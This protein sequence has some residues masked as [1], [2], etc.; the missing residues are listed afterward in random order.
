MLLNL[1]KL[2]DDLIVI[3]SEGYPF[4]VIHNLQK[5]LWKAAEIRSIIISQ[6]LNYADL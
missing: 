4:D 6:D 3:Q 2:K 5:E 1:H